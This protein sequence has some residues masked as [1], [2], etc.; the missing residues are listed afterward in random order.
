MDPPSATTKAA[1][2]TTKPARRRGMGRTLAPH[3]GAWTLSGHTGAGRAL[4]EVRNHP[5]TGAVENAKCLS[6]RCLDFR[7]EPWFL[8]CTPARATD[9]TGAQAR[10]GPG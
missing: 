9:E 6:H 1:S 4:P 2:A 3:A 7:G 10:R 8:P 5:H